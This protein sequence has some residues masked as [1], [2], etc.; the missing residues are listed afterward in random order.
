VG[1]N[2]FYGADD[3]RIIN[4]NLNVVSPD[5]PQSMY[6]HTSNVYINGGSHRIIRRG[7]GNTSSTTAVSQS[8]FT[9]ARGVVIENASMELI[10]DSQSTGQYKHDYP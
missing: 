2:A 9:G 10:A 1:Q 8:A 3:L 5:Q 7:R 4:G 6:D